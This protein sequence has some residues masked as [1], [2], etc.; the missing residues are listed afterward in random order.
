MLIEHAS[1]RGYAVDELL[2]HEITNSAFFLMDEDGWLP[3]E[4]CQITTWN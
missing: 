2:Q 4:E 1:H 3:E